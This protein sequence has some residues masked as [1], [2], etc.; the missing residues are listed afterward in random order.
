MIKQN[1]SEVGNDMALHVSDYFMSIEF[2][3][4]IS[5]YIIYVHDVTSYLQQVP[6]FNIVILMYIISTG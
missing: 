5:V 3:T 4:N 1:E 6:G 2:E